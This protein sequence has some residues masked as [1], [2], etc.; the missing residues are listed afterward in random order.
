[1]MVLVCSLCG[2][3]LRVA[4]LFGIF[5]LLLACPA[6]LLPCSLDPSSGTT[7]QRQVFR[8][9]VNPDTSF[10]FLHPH[11][12]LNGLVKLRV[13]FLNTTDMG[14]MGLGAGKVV[15]HLLHPHHLNGPLALYVAILLPSAVTTAS[16]SLRRRPSPIWGGSMLASQSMSHGDRSPAASIL[17]VH[18]S[19]CQEDKATM[20]R[21][22]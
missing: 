4:L 16:A 11:S 14:L 15:E 18:P 2:L 1:M 5:P 7:N 17:A 10:Y 19:R 3:M 21:P 20:H 9:L 8:Q 13:K 6:S 12:T 22:H